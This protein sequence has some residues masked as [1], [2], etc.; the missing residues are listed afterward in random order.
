MSPRGSFASGSW[1]FGSFPSW[2]IQ[3]A[4][5]PLTLVSQGLLRSGIITLQGSVFICS[6]IHAQG[7]LGHFELLLLVA[8]EQAA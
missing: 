4:T 5:D 2:F 1:S 3:E 8:C 6:P 7:Y